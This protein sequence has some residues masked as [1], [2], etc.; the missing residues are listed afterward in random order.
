[1]DLGV[2]CGL[3][4]ECRAGR[5]GIGIRD[6]GSE[7]ARVNWPTKKAVFSGDGAPGFIAVAATS[8]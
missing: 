7:R 4:V 5:Q 1:M 3:E 8:G 2:K 6:Q